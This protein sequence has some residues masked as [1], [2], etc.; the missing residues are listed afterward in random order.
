MLS[1]ITWDPPTPTKRWCRDYYAVWIDQFLVALDIKESV[2]I[3]E[4]NRFASCGISFFWWSRMDFRRR[5]KV[6][7]DTFYDRVEE[8][9]LRRFCGE[10]RI[11]G[12]FGDPR[13]EN[14][15]IHILLM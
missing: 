2:P 10:R 6:H 15:E 11:F 5:F 4:G 9:K 14:S 3:D 13:G 12:D 7:A 8:V 1:Q